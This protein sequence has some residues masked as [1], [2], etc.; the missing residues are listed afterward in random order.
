MKKILALVLLIAVCAIS[1]SQDLNA[2]LDKIKTNLNTLPF[3]YT[4]ED[5]SLKF[6]KI[7]EMPMNIS[8]DQLYYIAKDYIIKSYGDANRVIQLDDKEAGKITVKGL[9]AD[10]YCDCGD[11]VFIGSAM[12]YTATHILQIDLKDNR[13]R[14]TITVTQI[15]QKSGGTGTGFSYIPLKYLDFSPT[16][17]YPFRN[18][19]M[20]WSCNHDGG[21][22][23]KEGSIKQYKGNYHEG[24]I[25][26][27][28]AFRANA[29]I[30]ALYNA[31]TTQKQVESTS[32][33]W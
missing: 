4:V 1:Y 30:E 20:V 25:I 22:F 11:L 3:K 21:W 9:Y 15:K 6:Q 16:D 31:F 28:T 12:S 2:E 5:G 26:Y 7:Y 29:T 32:D 27:N 18:D 13:V 17:F 14:I 24:M 19:C 10:I 33:D 23:P 8:K